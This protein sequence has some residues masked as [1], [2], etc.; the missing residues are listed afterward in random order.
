[1][2]EAQGGNIVASPS[3]PFWILFLA[4]DQGCC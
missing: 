3:L 2:N 4:P 1:L